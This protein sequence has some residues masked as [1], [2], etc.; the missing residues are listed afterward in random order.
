MQTKQFLLNWILISYLTSDNFNPEKSLFFLHGWQ[1]DKSSFNKI[2]KL[3]DEKDISYIAIDFPWF[4]WSDFP[5]FD[6]TIYD[7][8]EFIEDFIKRI[9][10]VKPTLVWHSFW[11]RVCIVMWSSQYENINKLILIWAAW[12]KPETNKLRHIVTK[13]WKLVFSIPWLQW[14]WY[15]I[16]SKIWSRDYVNSGR[17]KNIFLNTINDDL[18]PLLEKIKYPTLLLRGLDDTE[19]PVADGILMNNTIDDTKIRIFEHWT[20]FVHDEFPKEITLEIE[21]FIS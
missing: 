4:W 2:Y 6:W 20:H 19:T 11:W 16:K 15:A 14:I 21:K 3:L 8:T 17:L 7:Y 18:T 5:K 9:G 13:A 12:I 1:Q 10:L